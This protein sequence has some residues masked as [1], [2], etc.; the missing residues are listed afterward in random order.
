MGSTGAKGVFCFNTFSRICIRVLKDGQG[1]YNSQAREVSLQEKEVCQ[2][3]ISRRLLLINLCLQVI[4][5]V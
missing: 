4:A 3:V 2:A 5:V 1:W